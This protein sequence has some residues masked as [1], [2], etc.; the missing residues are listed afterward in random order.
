MLFNRPSELQAFLAANAMLGQSDRYRQASQSECYYHSLQY[1]QLEPWES[2]VEL[3]RKRPRIVIPLYREAIDGIERFVWG[4]HRF[5]DVSVAATRTEDDPESADEIGPRLDTDQAEALTKF[6]R[7]L[8]KA[9]RLRRA[10]REFSRAAM[11]GTNSCAV[12][13]GTQGGHLVAH[14]EPGKHC[15]PT[16]DPAR[17]GELVALDIRYVHQREVQEGTSSRTQLFWYRREITATEDIVYVEVPFRPGVAPEWKRDAEK[18]VVHNLGFCPV[19]WVRVLPDSSDLVDGQPIVDPALLPMLDEVNY[20]VSLKNRA[21]QYGCDPW[22]VRTGVLDG[23]GAVKKSPGRIMDLPKGATLDLAETAGTG[24]QRAGEHLVDL[25]RRFRDA[26][27]YVKAAPEMSVGKIS[28]VVLE[29]L[30]A[31]MMAV[32]SDLRED[33]GEQAFVGLLNLALR[34][35]A[36]VVGRGEDVW[37]QGAAEAAR[38]ITA[39]QLSG[40]WL[41]VPMVL[42]WPPFFSQSIEEQKARV[43]ATNAAVAG[44]LIAAKTGTRAVAPLFGV[45]DVDDEHEKIEEETADAAEYGDL[46]GQ[47][48][49]APGKKPA[50][51][52][53]V[54]EPDD[55]KE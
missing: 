43:D 30:Y 46:L 7:A 53:P 45:E 50:T 11:T 36:V 6:L 51:R 16:Y 5:P 31:P 44:K 18:S 17:P 47:P 39:A 48:P 1:D 12:V 4:G 38:L 40:V 52:G 24:A 9:A 2:D 34:I 10:A 15:T 37:V 55:D 54:P 26:V 21:V 3:R 27:A 20:T 13:L 22:T 49:S 23:D 33:L 41:D 32:A 29:F 35:V 19:R 42:D 25:D 28:G 8:V 14:V